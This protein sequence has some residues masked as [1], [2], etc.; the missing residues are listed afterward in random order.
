MR[1]FVTTSLTPEGYGWEEVAYIFINTEDRGM[2]VEPSFRNV[3]SYKIVE[4]C[5]DFNEANIISKY[6]N[7]GQLEELT[8]VELR[9]RLNE[10]F[11]T[12]SS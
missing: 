6:K 8:V 2:F 11:S 12:K 1:Y 3:N 7:T 4:G 9:R 10:R 5:D